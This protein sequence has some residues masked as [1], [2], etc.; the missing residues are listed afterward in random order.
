M[1]E[2]IR[3]GYDQL[4]RAPRKTI[5][6]TGAANLGQAGTAVT[7]WTITGRVQ[8]LNF[9]SPFV[10]EA[11]VSTLNT[12]TISLGLT[13][14][15]AGFL[16]AA[17][18]GSGTFAINDWWVG[19]SDVTPSD[20]RD[21]AQAPFNFNPYPPISENIIIDCSTQD[22]TDGTLVFDGLWYRPLT[23]DGALT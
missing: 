21:I 22:I 11:L 4:V 2:I 6:F 8:V 7:V 14:V 15:V 20:G 3:A 10:T 9:P 13:N 12:G 5:A 19:A 18:V 17:T 16:Q 23:A 1:V